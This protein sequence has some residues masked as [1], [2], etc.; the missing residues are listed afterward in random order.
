MIISKT[1]LRASFFGGGTDFA[2]YYEN[3]R[4]G[5]GTVVSTAL[6][7]YVYI[8]V[9]K[10]FDDNIRIVY[11]GNELVSNVEEVKHNIISMQ[12]P[13]RIEIYTVS[14]SLLVV[15]N[16]IQPKMEDYVCSGIGL[17]NLQGR[18]LMLTGENIY[19]EKSNGYFKVFLPLLNVLG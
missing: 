10:K 17:K 8:T 16:P 1:P 6:D 3:S 7:M 13:L 11:S 4:L 18:Y 19:I 2:E 12:H 15:S 9:N 5:Y 14:E